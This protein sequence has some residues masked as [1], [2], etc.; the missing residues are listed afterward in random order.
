MRELEMDLLENLRDV[1]GGEVVNLVK[2]L[3]AVPVEE[4]LMC[5]ELFQDQTD[6]FPHAHAGN[7]LVQTVDPRVV[8]LLVDHLVILGENVFGLS[9]VAE[10]SPFRV[11]Y[12]LKTPKFFHVP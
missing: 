11:N 1:F 9:P 12:H 10:S 8:G 2:G 4:D 3:G 5:A 6:Q 7:E